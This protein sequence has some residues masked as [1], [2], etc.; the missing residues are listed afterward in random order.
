MASIA[1]GFSLAGCRSSLTSL[2]SVDDCATSKMMEFYYD[3]LGSGVSKDVAIQ[4]AKE[5][6]LLQA[7][8]ATSHPYF[9]AAFVQMGDTAPLDM[10]GQWP[11]SPWYLLALAVAAVLLFL[12][13]KH[14]GK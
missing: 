6:Y 5:S 2:W 12:W 4:Q 11:F 13:R 3:A 8:N 7:D 10:G 1:R 9:W 14:L